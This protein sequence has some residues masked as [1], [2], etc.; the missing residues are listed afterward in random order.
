MTTAR[1]LEILDGVLAGI[2]AMHATG[3]GHLDL[4]PDNVILRRGTGA[5]TLVD[6][7]LSGRHV[8]K[9][10][11]NPMYAPPEGWSDDR[12]PESAFAADSYSFACLAFELLT[13]VPLFDGEDLF[14][15]IR[16]HL[17]HDGLP[18]GVASLR[19]RPELRKLAEILSRALRANPAQ[20]TR[21][22]MFRTELARVA[23][24]LKDIEWPL[25]GASRWSTPSESLPSSIPPAS[26]PPASAPNAFAAAAPPAPSSSSRAVDDPDASGA[27]AVPTSGR[28]DTVAQDADDLDDMPWSD[29]RA[30]RT[31]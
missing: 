7:G 10:C 31:G 13:G 12:A 23:P 3:V 1:A 28:I 25:S 15:V 6:F 14:G 8:R 2:D 27:R 17:A 26:T 11:G 22:R 19:A 30:S 29:Y 4:K 24:S 20:R 21:I 16:Q 9:K 5:A 18:P